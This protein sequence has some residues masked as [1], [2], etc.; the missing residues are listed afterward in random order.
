[1]YHSWNFFLEWHDSDMA[2]AK[3]I[4]TSRVIN[5]IMTNLNFN[6]KRGLV[7]TTLFDDFEASPPLPKFLVGEDK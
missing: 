2:I 5:Q 4:V 1:M 3:M 7:H 6:Q